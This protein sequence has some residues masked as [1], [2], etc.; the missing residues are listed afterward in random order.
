MNTR[1]FFA[2]IFLSLLLPC[3]ASAASLD[4]M[5]AQIQQLLIIVAQLQALLAQ[6]NTSSGN[7]SVACPALSKNLSRGSEGSDVT[8]LQNFLISRG[9]LEAGNSTG[10]YGPLTETAVRGFQCK[11][12]GICSGSP[13]QNGY[14]VVGAQTRAKI[15]GMCSIAGGTSTSSTNVPSPVSSDTTN[16]KSYTSGQSTNPNPKS[17]PLFKV[18]KVTITQS[19]GSGNTSATGKTCKVGSTELADGAKQ[20]FYSTQTVSSGL[21]CSSVAQERTCNNGTMSGGSSY[22][23]TQCSVLPKAT[24]S[25]TS[26]YDFGGMYGNASGATYTNPATNAMSCPSG[27]SSAPILGSAGTDYDAYFCY[28]KN[29]E[30]SSSILDFGGTH[31]VIADGTTYKNPATNAASCPSGFISR[32]FFGSPGLDYPGY[33]CYRWRTPDSSHFFDF[34]GMY[35]YYSGGVYKNPAT[36]ADSCPS[37]YK[38]TP[39]VGS[40]GVDFNAYACH[41]EKTTT[42]TASCTFG[43]ATIYH[44]GS[45]PAFKSATVASGSS[46]QQEIR[47]CNNGKLSGSYPAAS[48]VTGSSSGGGTTSGTAGSSCTVGDITLTSGESKKFYLTANVPTGT[49]CD[50]TGMTQVRTCS[51]GVMTGSTAYDHA[52]CNTNASVAQNRT[53]LK[54]FTP[55]V[56]STTWYP[57]FN[58]TV[59]VDPDRSLA[60]L[61][62]EIDKIKAQGFNTVWMG[63]VA[64]WAQLQPT[65]GVWDEARFKNL[66]AHLELLKKKNMRAIYQLNYVGEGF[67]PTGIDGCYWFDKPDQ[68]QKFSDF[69]KELAGRLEEY[70]SMIYYMVYTEQTK[71]CLL[72]RNLPYYYP[73]YK[74]ESISHSS[75]VPITEPYT[76]Y[77]KSDATVVNNFLKASIGSLPQKLPKAI[78]EQMFIGIHD[79]TVSRGFITGDT[80]VQSPNNFDYFSFAFYPDENDIKLN[81]TYAFA[82]QQLN[83]GLNR[84]RAHFPTTPIILG[85]FGWPTWNGSQFVAAEHSSGRDATYTAMLDWSI[86]NKIGFNTWA[87]LPRF[88]D[89]PEQ[90]YSTYEESLQLT[91]RNG[92]LTST[93]GIIRNKLLGY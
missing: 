82:L 91:L 58:N 67:S 33:S 39:I 92:T 34:G 38:A 86:M 61:A 6:Q 62:K 1:T 3:M 35:G 55:Y 89:N 63:G 11:H 40:A 65:P 68:V 64:I 18:P 24:D 81:S 79:V 53:L 19:T 50:E 74:M 27:Y 10:F 29:V 42:G 54:E 41:K 2:G 44:G 25:D 45:I 49:S 80:P 59:G 83:A 20:T 32:P 43:S 46:C 72:K 36:G 93:L 17:A 26:Y 69:T 56:W 47:T 14:G 76:S 13:E 48:C 12:M 78:R 16:S 7:S 73:G 31:G 52:S 21:S 51:N 88:I 9:H 30:G 37:G 60:L 15:A 66:V 87:W 85:E 28:R 23:H 75:S 70:N 71:S 5:R 4:E 57:Y 77:Q 8:S 90:E 22:T 84:I